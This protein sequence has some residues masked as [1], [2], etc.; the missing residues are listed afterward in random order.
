MRPLVPSTAW[1][2]YQQSLGNY[3]LYSGSSQHIYIEMGV[4]GK[5][6]CTINSCSVDISHARK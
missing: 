3:D 4:G 5:A 2:I 1:N 6:G